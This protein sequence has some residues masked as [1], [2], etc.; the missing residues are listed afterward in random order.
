M[1]FVLLDS[2]P[3][4]MT[5]EKLWETV[6]NSDRGLQLA[7]TAIGEADPRLAS[8]FIQDQ[9][10][11]VLRCLFIKCCNRFKHSAKQYWGIM[12]LNRLDG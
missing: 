3:L 1:L 4:R 12:K 6:G 10:T 11:T 8:Y 9:Q 5:S 7:T 2:E